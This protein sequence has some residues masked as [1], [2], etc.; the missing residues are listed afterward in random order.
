MPRGEKDKFYK[1]AIKKIFNFFD[2]E[3]KRKNNFQDR[4]FD[5][6][7]EISDNE[8]KILE[9]IS[10]IAL[11]SVANQWSIIQSLKHIKEKN[12][13]GEVV[14]C[15]VYKGGSLILICLIAQML[16]LKKE[17]I[18]YDTFENGFDSISEFDLSAKGK[19]I[20]KLSFEKNFFPTVN[21][22]LNIIKKFNIDSNFYPKLVKGK[23]QDTLL[24]DENVPDSISFL[25][26]DT[27]IYEPTAD[28]LDK[29]YPKLS[30][31]GILHIDDYGHCPGVKKAV[32]E[33]FVD[34]KIW[35]HRID[36]TCR[37]LIKD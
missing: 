7:T 2:L 34:K 23:T 6:V 1:K 4:Y 30:S 20:E 17:I 25:R 18:G 37:L 3:I 8:K 36:Y 27:D 33:Y 31:G 11:S 24:L 19:K 9:K 29:L 32:D 22:V 15:G 35:L 14:E 26:L 21:E 12:I 16:E 13:P 5:S 28:Q 10:E